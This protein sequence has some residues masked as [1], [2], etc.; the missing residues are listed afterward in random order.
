MVVE[1]ARDVAIGAHVVDI[2][3]RDVL[4]LRPEDDAA[5]LEAA[6]IAAGAG[7]IARLSDA[8]VKE[9]G[10]A[11]FADAPSLTLDTFA[12]PCAARC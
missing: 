6:R 10:P 12:D 3:A 5:K 1:A 2:Y 11:L 4:A 9:I 8:T 7:V